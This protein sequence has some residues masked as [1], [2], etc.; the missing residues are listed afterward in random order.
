MPANG[1]AESIRGTLIAIGGG[2]DKLKE[3][4]V[5]SRVVALAGGNQAK[6]ALIP[7]ASS[8]PDEMA[9]IYTKVFA[10]LGAAETMVMA[11]DSR[12]QA[13]DPKELEKLER[14][15][16]TF[17]TGGDQLRLV[18]LLGGT[19]FVTA[20]RRRNAAG[21]PIAGTSAGAGAICQHMI[22]RGRSGQALNQRMV[23]LAPGLGLTNRMVVDQ[24]FSQRHRMGRLFTAVA[25]NPF[26]V[27]VGIDEDTGAFLDGNNQL[28]VH[29]AGS[30]TVIDGSNIVYTDIADI[31]TAR[32][33]SVLGLS[34][35]VLTHGCS[36]DLVSRVATAPTKRPG[37]KPTLIPS[38]LP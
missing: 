32:P 26:L 9:A 24:H 20:L 25:L 1:P 17:F 19:P 28:T 29:G 6:I 12:A 27:G 22:A 21:M 38:E 3:K 15:T 11:I 36:F 10:E 37:A 2:E 31:Q 5:L 30:V 18:S 34:V 33:G 35:H 16:L 7:T 4:H 23:N 13:G 8:I 14:A